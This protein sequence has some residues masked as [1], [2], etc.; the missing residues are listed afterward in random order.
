[1]NNGWIKLHRKLRDNPIYSSPKALHVWIECLLRAC[2]EQKTFYSKSTKIILK[3]G[4]FVMGRD[5]FG[6]NIGISGST[7]W[8][9]LQIFKADSMIDIKTS[10]KGSVVTVL[11]WEEYQKVDSE[12]D[13][14]RTA[15]EQRMN[16]N[17]NDKNVKNDKNPPLGERPPIEGEILEEKNF[18]NKKSM[19]PDVLGELAE[20]FQVPIDFVENSWDTAS[21]W[22]TAKGKIQKDY[23]AFF[24]NWLKKDIA[25]H[26]LKYK[27]F[28]KNNNGKSGIAIIR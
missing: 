8:R 28:N 21:N 10:T 3:P 12:V 14:K 22:L 23:K 7:A 16:T 4:E 2:H 17:K 11:K 27:Q 15:D 9:W 25:E 1:M 19:T 24:T 26:L 18:G 5:E 20:R 13:N 6:K